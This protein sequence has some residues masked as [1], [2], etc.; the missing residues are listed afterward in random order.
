VGMIFA[1]GCVSS[2]HLQA[3]SV[4]RRPPRPLL[5]GTDA[6][7]PEADISVQRPEIVLCQTEVG[8]SQAS[9]PASVDSQEVRRAAGPIT[10]VALLLFPARTGVHGGTKNG[11]EP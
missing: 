8:L 4:R 11:A 5:E 2:F 9:Q 1:G 6:F 3:Y 7:E 10:P